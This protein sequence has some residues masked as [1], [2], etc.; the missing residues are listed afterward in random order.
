MLTISLIAYVAIGLIWGI[1]DMINAVEVNENNE[2]V[3]QH[4]H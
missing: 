1:C 2:P 4:N 3:A